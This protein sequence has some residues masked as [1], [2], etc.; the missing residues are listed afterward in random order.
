MKK[1]K[2]KKK[3]RTSSGGADDLPAGITGLENN[4]SVVV[5]MRSVEILLGDLHGYKACLAQ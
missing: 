4:T 5:G 3:K 1:K 2:K